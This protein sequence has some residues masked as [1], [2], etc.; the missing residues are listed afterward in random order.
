MFLQDFNGLV[1]KCTFQNNEA[2]G[3]YGGGIC[4][5]GKCFKA[6]ILK[7]TFLNNK[8][9][10][11][12]GGLATF[13]IGVNEAVVDG[14]FFAGNIARY[15]EHRNTYLAQDMYG[16]RRHKRPKTVKNNKYN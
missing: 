15:R 4:L 10:A 1:E 13:I 6:R 5:Q 11:R 7:N 16:Q 14:N 2:R 9:A 12:G 8:A 3:Y